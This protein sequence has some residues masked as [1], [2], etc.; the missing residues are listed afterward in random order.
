M[1]A[2]GRAQRDIEAMVA[3][4]NKAAGAQAFE[5]P[6]SSLSFTV[7][8]VASLQ[9]VPKE[10]TTQRD[11][12]F[13]ERLNGGP[14]V[15][16]KHQIGHDIYLNGTEIGFVGSGSEGPLVAMASALAA[17]GRPAALKIDWNIARHDARVT[18]LVI[19]G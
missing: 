12:T 16:G 7:N 15:F 14:Y 1:S 10:I 13:L 11:A 4:V 8:D 5:G 17:L 9:L 6:P 18:S 19:T 3:A 2:V